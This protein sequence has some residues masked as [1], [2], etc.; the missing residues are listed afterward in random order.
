MKKKALKAKD[1]NEDSNKIFS[2]TDK[3]HDGIIDF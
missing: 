3:N 2:D 1:M